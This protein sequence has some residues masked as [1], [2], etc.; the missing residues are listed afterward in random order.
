MLANPHRS[1]RRRAGVL[2]AVMAMISPLLGSAP[3]SAEPPTSNTQWNVDGLSSSQVTAVPLKVRAIAN[4]G[5]TV[6]VGG[7]FTEVTGPNGERIGQPFLAA[8]DRDTG[9]WKADFRPAVNGAVYSIVP[10][11]DGQSIFVGGEFSTI[12]GQNTGPVA[13]LFLDGSVV[14]GFQPNL[15]ATGAGRNY[16]H[17]VDLDGEHLIIGGEFRTVNGVVRQRLAR[18]RQA[19]G[20]L[21]TN[22]DPMV[23]GGAVW[24][25]EVS[26]DLDRI[27]L[28]G[29]FSSVNDDGSQRSFAA[30]GRNGDLRSPGGF[31]IEDYEAFQ[32]EMMN[33]FDLIETGTSVIVANQ[34]NTLIV[35][36]K[37][38]LQMNHYFFGENFLDPLPYKGS[39]YQGIGNVG[40]RIF[41]GTHMKWTGTPQ[42][43]NGNGH[44]DSRDVSR[45][46]VN[47]I[48]ELDGAGNQQDSFLP[49]PLEGSV[50]EIADVG[51]GCFWFGGNNLTVQGVADLGFGE[52][53][54]ATADPL[55][56]AYGP[57][58]NA[59]HFAN[60]QYLDLFG[61]TGDA[62]G[63]RF[64]AERT[65][66]DVSNADDVIAQLMGAAEFD[67]RRQI[68]RLYLGLFGRTPDV[69]G[70]EFWT[71]RR[72]AG[73]SLQSI[74]DGFLGSPE[75]A[76]LVGTVDNREFARQVYLRV[77]DREPDAAGLDFWTGRLNAG[78]ARSAMVVNF[79]ESPEFVAS[80][81]ARV[82][83]STVYSGMLRRKADPAGE[84]FWTDRVAATG[85]IRTLI[86]GIFDS[87]EYR[88]RFG[89]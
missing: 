64:W 80:T 7:Q 51:N 4:I 2:V 22:F 76:E 17:D 85:D 3:A 12:G 74:T 31:V 49:M 48:L 46:E 84:D 63:V 16:V 57:F 88:N 37:A 56:R 18:V 43:R 33:S 26:D 11:A 71:G 13:R 36:D 53:C 73:Q 87:A 14:T 72:N 44:V 54:L 30:V 86:A 39:D 66:A 67:N 15:G 24:A 21:D 59:Y 75:F 27:Y 69:E 78:L 41:V 25:V 19:D 20:V 23:L 1:L 10:A 8:F 55:N 89:G 6:Y 29:Q 58:D 50:W 77:L 68:V 38:S 45:H 82:S 60:Q 52:I 32:G 28:G 34:A 79:T 47:V 35:L 70:L 62:D 83:V 42:Q 40:G 9:A 81:D 65:N 61:R 5:D